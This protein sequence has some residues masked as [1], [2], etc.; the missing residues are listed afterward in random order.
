MSLMQIVGSSFANLPN[1]QHLLQQ[2]QFV[3]LGGSQLSHAA[4]GV[5]K[6]LPT[7]SSNGSPETQ[8]SGQE[9]TGKSDKKSR[10]HSQQINVINDQGKNENIQVGKRK[11]FSLGTESTSTK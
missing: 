3:P 7:H 1:M 10:S 11:H 2:S 4:G 5:E 9:N 8:R 6:S